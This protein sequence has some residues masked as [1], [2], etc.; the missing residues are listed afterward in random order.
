MP[1]TPPQHGLASTSRYDRHQHLYWKFLMWSWRRWAALP[2]APR[3]QRLQLQVAASAAG[4]GRP[5]RQVHGVRAPGGRT[6][7]T[8][9]SAEPVARP[10]GECSYVFGE[11]VGFGG[12]FRCTRRLDERFG[13]QR[14]FNTPLCEQT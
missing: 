4:G 12:V 13:K 14:V 5:A 3:G 6:V 9:A 11:D 1:Q 8:G 2:D 7:T 10:T